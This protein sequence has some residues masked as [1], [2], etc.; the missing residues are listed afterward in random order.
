M[1]PTT[2]FIYFLVCGATGFFLWYKMLGIMESKGR[3]V[4]YLV[5]GPSQLVEFKKII[6]EETDPKSKQLY[7]TIFWIQI[8][9]VPIY[10]IGLI[11][12]IW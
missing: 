10:L 1:F 2:L 5:A 3:K 7:R 9:L 12:L 8:V 4:N 11:F 6:D